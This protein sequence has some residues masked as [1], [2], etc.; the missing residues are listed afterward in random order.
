M[1]TGKDRHSNDRDSQIGLLLLGWS[2]AAFA[3]LLLLPPIHITAGAG[4]APG[5]AD[6][7][8][9]KTFITAAAAE[10]EQAPQARSPFADPASAATISGTFQV[11][12]N[13]TRRRRNSAAWQTVPF[14]TGRLCN[15]G[16]SCYRASEL[17]RQLCHHHR[18][19]TI[20][21]GGLPLRSPAFSTIDQVIGAL[22]KQAIS[23]GLQRF[24]GCGS[25]HVLHRRCSVRR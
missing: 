9:T 19:G 22:C 2:S 10:Y 18:S 16:P 3:A 7:P 25:W 14:V 12:A 6:D 20:A 13:P 11:W 23:A 1:P 17:T 15:G 21:L 5:S 8:P 4:Q 24:S